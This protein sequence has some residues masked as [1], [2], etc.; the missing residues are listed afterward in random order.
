MGVVTLVTVAIEGFPVPVSGHT[1]ACM[2]TVVLGSLPPAVAAEVERRRAIGADR[3]DEVWD[4]EYRMAPGPNEDHGIVDAEVVGVLRPYARRRGLTQVTAFN[5][6]TV[7][8]FRVPDHGLVRRRTGGAWVPTA[9]LVV[10][11]VS[12][13]DASWQKFDFYA[14]HEVDEVVIVD[15]ADHSV[16]WFARDGSEYHPVERSAVLDVDV[17][18]VVAQV[19]WH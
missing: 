16:A 2:E 19:D 1:V 5:I 9:A 11:V 7:T 15:P 18:E 8:N 6:G 13:G 12:P 4:G 14:A 10:E 3:Y 17:A